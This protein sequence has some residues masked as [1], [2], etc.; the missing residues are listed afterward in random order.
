MF[1]FNDVHEFCF[2]KI[3]SVKFDFEICHDISIANLRL[4][5]E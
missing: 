5:I 2:E 1:V 3:F 4:E